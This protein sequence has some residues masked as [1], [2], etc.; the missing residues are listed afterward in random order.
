MVFKNKLLLF[1]LLCIFIVGVSCACCTCKE[2]DDKNTGKKVLGVVTIK[3]NNLS[4]ASQKIQN[5]I[6]KHYTGI[7][8]YKLINKE[9][10][11]GNYSLLKYKLIKVNI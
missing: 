7:V 1:L 3:V 11:V 5:Y 6:K 8:D 9:D 4:L 2:I 10:K